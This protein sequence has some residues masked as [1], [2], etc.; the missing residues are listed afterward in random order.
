MRQQPTPPTAAH[1]CKRFLILLKK[2]SKLPQILSDKS[3][4]FVIHFIA[5]I[6][7]F[8]GIGTN[9]FFSVIHCPGPGRGCEELESGLGPEQAGRAAGGWAGTARTGCALMSLTV[10]LLCLTSGK[11]LSFVHIGPFSKVSSRTRQKELKLHQERFRL[12]IK[13]KFFTKRLL[14]HWTRLPREVVKSPWLEVLKKHL[15]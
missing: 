10:S 1:L 9:A 6:G 8:T 2:F 15:D 13:K 3:T 14:K 4:L 7:E 5:L 11:I 12:H